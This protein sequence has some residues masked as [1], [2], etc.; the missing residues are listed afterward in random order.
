VVATFQNYPRTGAVLFDLKMSYPDGHEQPYAMD[1]FIVMS[2]YDAFVESLTWR[3]HGVYVARA[4]LYRQF[5]YDESC[6]FYSDDNTTRQH[7][8]HA[9]EVRTCSGEYHYL[10]HDGSATHAF[11][12]QRFDYL[13][14]NM[15]MKRQLEQ[16]GVGEEVLDVYENHRWLNV[17]DMYMIYHRNGRQLSHDE[18]H[19]ALAAIR[20]AWESIEMRRVRPGLKFKF[21]YAPMRPSMEKMERQV[22]EQGR[23]ESGKGEGWCFL[24]WRLFRME[25]ELYFFLRALKD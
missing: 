19:K 15:S 10:Q 14:A 3:I 5:P 7:Y 18:A 21:G 23:R 12:L 2:G 8:L 13:K 11:S 20:E 24:Y 1:P 9:D 16:L 25:E 17:I 4:D 6:K 22:L